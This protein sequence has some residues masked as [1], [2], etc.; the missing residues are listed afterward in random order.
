VLADGIEAVSKFMIRPEDYGIKIPGVVRN[1]I[2][3]NIE[4]SVWIK[5]SGI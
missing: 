1:K 2:S 5:Y 3:E 4:V